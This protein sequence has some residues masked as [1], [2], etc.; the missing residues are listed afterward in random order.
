MSEYEPFRESLR[1]ESMRKRDWVWSLGMVFVVALLL[2]LAW[3][4][5][6]CGTVSTVA[7]RLPQVADDVET[8]LKIHQCVEQAV[9][10]RTQRET[11]RLLEAKRP[12][13]TDL[14]EA[15][16]GVQ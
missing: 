12:I 6:S 11:K 16:G 13:Y 3:M 8:A 9:A 1:A 15:D 4:T 14:Y 10:E 5:A 7:D 2:A